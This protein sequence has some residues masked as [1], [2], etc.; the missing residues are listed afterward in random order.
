[1]AW[2]KGP[3]PP[4]TYYW[5]GVVPFDHKGTGFYFAEFFGDHVVMNPFDAK[6]GRRLEPHEVLWWNNAL[7]LP[8]TGVGLAGGNPLAAGGT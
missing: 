1:M 8:P 2:Q 5:G 6:D 7:D 3:L 4:G